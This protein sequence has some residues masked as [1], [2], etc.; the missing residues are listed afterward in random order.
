MILP[1]KL[2]SAV[3][4]D[5][6]ALLDSLYTEQNVSSFDLRP[7][8]A[9][10]ISR[11]VIFNRTS[12][13]LDDLVVNCQWNHRE[14]AKDDFQTVHTDHGV[15]F[16]FSPEMSSISQT[17]SSSG[18]AMMLNVEEY[19]YMAGPHSAA[20]LKILLM[21]ENEVPFVED[22]GDNLPTGLDSFIAVNPVQKVHLP[23]PHTQ[24]VVSD[25]YSQSKCYG[26]CRS[27]HAAE[28]CGCLDHYM[29]DDHHDEARPH[30]GSPEESSIIEH[31][32]TCTLEEYRSC[33]WGALDTFNMQKQCECPIA[34]KD[35]TFQ[36]TITYAVNPSRSTSSYGIDEVDLF[37]KHLNAKEVAQRVSP[38]IKQKDALLIHALHDTHADVHTAITKVREA[39]Y[40]AQIYIKRQISDI[41]PRMAFHLAW[42]LE[43]VEF[44]VANDFVRLWDV[45]DERTLAHVTT[46]F[47]QETTL[48]RAS[49]NESMH[50]ART[51]SQREFIYEANKRNLLTRNMLIRRALVN[52][53]LINVAFTTGT[54]DFC[55][56]KS[57]HRR[58]DH[59]WIPH[60]ILS[61]EE[62]RNTYYNSFVEYMN[63][64]L[65]MIEIFSEINADVYFN[66]VFDQEELEA[67]I[68]TFEYR[69]R[70]Y[71]LYRYKYY[72]RIVIPTW[73]KTKLRLSQ[74]KKLRM[75]L[76][77]KI[78][79][80]E[81]AIRNINI[82]IESFNESAGASLANAV[83]FAY[84]YLYRSSER[85]H[86]IAISMNTK[87]I[88]Q[89]LVAFYTMCKDFRARAIIILDKWVEFN[90]AVLDVWS[91]MLYENW[92]K[93]FYHSIRRDIEQYHITGSYQLREI[94]KEILDLDSLGNRTLQ[95]LII[96]MNA[97]F[98]NINP[99]EFL[100]QRRQYYRH[101]LEANNII[102]IIGDSPDHFIKAFEALQSDLQTYL[103]STV[104]NSEFY[105]R[106]LLRLNIYV[107]SLSYEVHQH[108]PAYD[109]TA[110]LCDIGGTLSLCIGASAITIFEIFDA[111]FIHLL[112]KSSQ[113]REKPRDLRD[114]QGTVGFRNNVNEGLGNNCNNWKNAY[115]ASR[116]SLKEKFQLLYLKY[117]SVV[118]SIPLIGGDDESR[119]Q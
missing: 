8:S 26:D 65:H 48:F 28:Q 88:S 98:V 92:T 47:Y 77:E 12:H 60:D 52:I 54:P 100:L 38:E 49:L 109:V 31:Y 89:D 18:L 6:Y 16:Q 81:I 37:K 23:E 51:E 68:A 27:H 69:C 14:C 21:G 10:N 96:A 3:D 83:K 115:E 42:G 66:R 105:S 33:I 32:P 7:Y 107:K 91:S 40:H 19:E 99:D 20:G 50:E 116:I 61:Y 13:Q 9:L 119:R 24:C 4:Q 58:Y 117:K 85:K 34:C 79:D 114:A 53:T 118:S 45:L 106:N 75:T 70:S 62:K 5:W 104:L 41:E 25:T 87:E 111:I 74:F 72:S 102:D 35:T 67:A 2:S 36:S 43:K 90:E 44:T 63:L 15:C 95:D 64:L 11:M 30:R 110:L 39:L 108:L 57:P 55:F 82:L 1:R 56:K 71:N 84:Q 22:F 93:P 29:N 80:M 73:D 101:A 94:F 86:D 97:D 76:Y 78:D 59:D 46:G 103:L 113:P 17:G 112:K